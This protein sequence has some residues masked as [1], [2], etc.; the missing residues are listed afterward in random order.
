MATTFLSL[1][2]EIC[3]TILKHTMADAINNEL[4]VCFRTYDTGCTSWQVDESDIL[5]NDRGYLMSTWL[6][7]PT[8]RA[9]RVHHAATTLRLVSAQTNQDMN[10]VLEHSTKK[11]EKDHA[12]IHK[13]NSIPWTCGTVFK[14]VQLLDVRPFSAKSFIRGSLD[15]EAFASDNLSIACE[16]AA[17]LQLV[18]YDKGWIWRL[19][20]G[21]LEVVRRI[22]TWGHLL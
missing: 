4:P 5:P 19:Q 17:M 3:Q 1:P 21:E 9:P 11:F 2:R 18:K 7:E 10:H 13:L 14:V 12:I 22:C 15:L 6:F 20:I 16:Y 8:H